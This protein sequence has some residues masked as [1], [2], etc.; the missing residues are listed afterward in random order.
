M[1]RGRTPGGAVR[2][3]LDLTVSEMKQIDRTIWLVFAR[4]WHRSTNAPEGKRRAESVSIFVCKIDEEKAEVMAFQNTRARPITDQA[5]AE[6]WGAFD[7]SWER[8][9]MGNI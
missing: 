6:S 1:Q 4:G 8:R 3:L 2:Y 5:S 7:V 9:E